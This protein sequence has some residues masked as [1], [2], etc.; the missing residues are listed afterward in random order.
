MHENILCARILTACLEILLLGPLGRLPHMLYLYSLQLNFHSL[1]VPSQLMGENQPFLRLSMTE[2]AKKVDR[3]HTCMALRRTSTPDNSQNGAKSSTS[4]SNSSTIFT[5]FS[6]AN[7]HQSSKPFGGSLRYRALYSFTAAFNVR[8]C[9]DSNFRNL[10]S[11]FDMSLGIGCSV[12][13]CCEDF[14]NGVLKVDSETQP[15]VSTSG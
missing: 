2:N 4:P 12:K 11:A 15:L 3:V 10:S 13:D 7:F 6:C 8:L 1:L 14:V 9:F 5:S